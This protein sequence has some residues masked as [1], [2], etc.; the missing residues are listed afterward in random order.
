[1]TSVDEFF[2]TQFGHSI[3][4]MTEGEMYDILHNL[5]S[6]RSWIAI[7]KYGQLR[8]AV[9]A[10]AL[11]TLDPVKDPTLIARTQGALSGL[12][13]LEEVVYRLNN[14]AKEMDQEA[15]EVDVG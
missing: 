12:S 3:K 14:P 11:C 10:G 13:D 6:A 8:R 15:S 4:E 1:M 7:L 5:P 9:A 2:N